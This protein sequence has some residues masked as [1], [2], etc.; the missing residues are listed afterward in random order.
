M[1]KIFGTLTLAAWAAM[2]VPAHAASPY[3]ID[4]T[5]CASFAAS[6]SVD[7]AG[8]FAGENTTPISNVI[9]VANTE[10]YGG[11]TWATIVGGT[12]F[13]EYKDDNSGA[14]STTSLIDGNSNGTVTFLSAVSGPF[15]LALKYGNEFSAFLYTSSTF[16]VG[17]AITFN[18]AADQ[19]G[20]SHAA[21]YTNSVTAV[22]EPETYALMLAGLGVVSFV[23]K[24][25]KAA[26]QAV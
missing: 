2:A 1:K 14:G 20:L 15:I 11:P 21:I 18:A 19:N 22:P 3:P 5:P 4:G 12:S 16:A 25:R 26:A 24:R 17:D 6:G 7:C 23:S 8:G 13:T 9:N 10:T